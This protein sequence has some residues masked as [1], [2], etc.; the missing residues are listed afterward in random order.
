MDF[1]SICSIEYR[2]DV[3]RWRFGQTCGGDT[4]GSHNV[5]PDGHSRPIAQGALG[6]ADLDELSDALKRHL[7]D[8][9][10]PDTPT[11]TLGMGRKLAESFSIFL[12]CATLIGG[13]SRRRI[14][15]H[16]IETT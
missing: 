6:A 2:A 8:P 11:S 15:P 12:S 3:V 9:N 5:T 7:D 14:Q 16:L 1:R 4:A 10:T 13:S